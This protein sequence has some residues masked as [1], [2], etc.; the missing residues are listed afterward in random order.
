MS[1]P[2]YIK[3]ANINLNRVEE[4]NLILT[5]CGTEIIYKVLF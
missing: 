1:L 4:E 3:Y 2:Y 5:N